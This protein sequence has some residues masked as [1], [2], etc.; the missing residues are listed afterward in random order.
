MEPSYLGQIS[1]ADVDGEHVHKR[2][3]ILWTVSSCFF[4]GATW[5]SKRICQRPRILQWLRL[6]LSCSIGAAYFELP[7]LRWGGRRIIMACCIFRAYLV[8]CQE[9]V[10]Y[11]RL[12]LSTGKRK[13]SRTSIYV[14][15]IACSLCI[16]DFGLTYFHNQDS[17]REGFPAQ[18]PDTEVKTICC[19]LVVT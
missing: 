17:T 13:E 12:F 4:S 9:F 3:S 7:T 15:L 16:L 10:F 14:F 19:R 2:V 18:M 1:D 6:L 8:V 11:N 5:R